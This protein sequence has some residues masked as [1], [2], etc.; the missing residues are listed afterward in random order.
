MKLLSTLLEWVPALLAVV[1]IYWF[2]IDPVTVLIF[3]TGTA[4]ILAIVSVVFK[5]R[6]FA[7]LKGALNKFF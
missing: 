2:I 4:V 7:W 6:L 3:L 1:V 5:L